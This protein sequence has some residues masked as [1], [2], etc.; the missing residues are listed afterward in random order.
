M[1]KIDEGREVMVLLEVVRNEEHKEQPF[2]MKP[3][4]EE[5]SGVIPKEI[6]HGLPPIRDIQHHIDLISR[7]VLPNKASYRMS[8]KEREEF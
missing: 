8:P 2:I 5:S 3:L 6:P 1:K 7:V 4:L